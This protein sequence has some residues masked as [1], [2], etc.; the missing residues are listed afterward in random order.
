[1]KHLIVYANPEAKSFCKSIADTLVETLAAAGKEY[2]FRDLYEEKFD[3]ILDVADFVAIAKNDYLIDIKIEQEIIQDSSV[4]TF[5]YP[6]WWMGAPAILKGYFDRVFA[7]KFAYSSGV[8]GLERG[9]IGKKAVV[10]NT[11]GGKKEIYEQNGMLEAMRKLTDVGILEY[12]GLE[13]VEH[14]FFGGIT[15]STEEDRLKMLQEVR[16]LGAKMITIGVETQRASW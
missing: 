1:M 5:I 3:P 16:E 14:K 11:M 2:V 9:F 12:T 10:I 7:E 13:V 8:N 6:I 15:T 4:L